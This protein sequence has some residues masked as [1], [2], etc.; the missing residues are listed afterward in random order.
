MFVW[1]EFEKLNKQEEKN[2]MKLQTFMKYGFICASALFLIGAMFNTNGNPAAAINLLSL[3]LLF[4]LVAV[5]LPGDLAISS[6][7]LGYRHTVQPQ[8][9]YQQQMQQF[10][11]Q[12]QRMQP[13]QQPAIQEK[14]R[15]DKIKEY[16]KKLDELKLKAEAQLNDKPPEKPKV[17]TRRPIKDDDDLTPNLYINLDKLEGN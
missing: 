3:S 6:T 10:N 17:K 14:T 11:P 2:K 1:F 8:P 9:T 4:C 15:E 16:L 7:P 12:Q 13:I 5:G